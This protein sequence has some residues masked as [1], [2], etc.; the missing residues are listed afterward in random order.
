METAITSHKNRLEN[1]LSSLSADDM[2]WAMKFLA[3][4][5]SSR[6]KAKDNKAVIDERAK[7]EQF[8]NAVCGKWED[9]KDADEMVN[10]IYVGR[11]NKDFTQL[12]NIFG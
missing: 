9:D 8:L 7:T 2:A 12:D 10:D 11:A 5:L 6:L 4:R 1:I 3:D